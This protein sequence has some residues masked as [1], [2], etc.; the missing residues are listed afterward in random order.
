MEK[1]F[2]IPMVSPLY[3]KTITRFLNHHLLVTTTYKKRLFKI[4]QLDNIARYLLRIGSNHIA[5]LV[6][7]RLDKESFS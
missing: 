2:D 4:K 7:D 6:L 5:F 3:M 1:E